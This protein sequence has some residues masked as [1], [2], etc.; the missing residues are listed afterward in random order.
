MKDRLA[1]LLARWI[2]RA[3]RAVAGMSDARLAG[4]LGAVERVLRLFGKTGEDLAALVELREIA[5]T[6]PRGMTL[7][8]N[9]ILEGRQEQLLALLRGTLKHYAF[10]GPEGRDLEG[11]QPAG[12]GRGPLL[13]LGIAGDHQD[14]AGLGRAYRERDRCQAAAVR[15]E[16]LLGREAALEGLSALE[17]SAPALANPD[18]LRGALSRGVAVSVHH[19]CFD[20]PEAV[21]AALNAAP[22]HGAPFRVF[23][24]A[25]YY[26]PVVRLKSLLD[27]SRV[28]EVC[29]IR[30]RATLGGSGGAAAPVAPDP[31]KYL[32]HPA[33]D[34]LLLMT[35]LGGEVERVAAYL[36]P[37]DPQR[38]GQ[39]VLSCKFARP[40]RYGL[41]ELTWAP[42]LYLRSDHSPHD[43]EVEVA[44]SD[45]ILWLTRGMAERTRAAP[46]R[47]RVAQESST[48]GIE[49]GLR[50]DWAAVYASAAGEM[51]RMISARARPLIRSEEIVSAY[52]L[53][54]RAYEAARC[55]ETLAV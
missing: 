47:L 8:R 20:G 41:L 38:G 35:F 5:Q 21:G 34:Q 55:R 1:R 46:I 39:G 45:G 6:D 54:E 32:T 49:A 26:P 48:I 17:I 42:G 11:L 13:R 16:E 29:N 27:A 4:L 30:I 40:G 43:L 3:L 19:S 18:F 23:H 10:G 50:E 31:E 14:L 51:V 12:K 25:L 52:R 2:A 33:F 37:M 28:G 7:L 24:P 44:G 36:N 9:L 53:R 22:R 15:A